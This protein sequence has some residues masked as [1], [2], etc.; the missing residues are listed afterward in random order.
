[1][2]DTKQFI[3]RYLLAFVAFVLLLV[4]F[5]V[6]SF[7]PLAAKAVQDMYVLN[8]HE[9]FVKDTGR[10]KE[11]FMRYIECI[12]NNAVR[13]GKITD[14]TRKERIIFFNNCIK[15]RWEKVWQ[16][17]PVQLYFKTDEEVND[18][19]A[20][21]EKINEKNFHVDFVLKYQ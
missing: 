15:T 7:F 17:I 18:F 8:R 6:L 13:E 4:A 1:M 9:R 2:L 12:L 5:I 11:I 21:T 14:G 10:Q 3:F 19:I 16:Q 20:N